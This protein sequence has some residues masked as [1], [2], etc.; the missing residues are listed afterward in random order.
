MTSGDKYVAIRDMVTSAPV[1]MRARSFAGFREL[2][3]SRGGNVEALLASVGLDPRVL[4][5]PEAAVPFARGAA[6]L[7]QAAE[8]LDLPDIGLRLGAYQ[9]IS[10]LGPVALVARHA[11]DLRG[12]LEGIGRHMAYHNTGMRLDLSV[13][14][15]AGEARLQCALRIDENVPVRHAMELTFVVA[16]KFLRTITQSDGIGWDVRFRHAPG[17]SSARYRKAFGCAAIFQQP[18]DAISF[19]ARLLDTAVDTANAELRRQA[20]RYIAHVVRRFPL[21]IASQTQALVERQLATGDCNIALIAGMLRLHERTLQRR[22]HEQGL[23][24]DTIVDR[25]RRERAREYLLG[26]AIPLTQVA[27]LLGYSEHTAF[28]R[29]C[30]R[31]FGESPRKLRRR[32]AD[33]LGAT[34]R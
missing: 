31:W 4:G 25:L 21:D 28:T 27:A 10:V 20:E 34:N 8:A 15:I 12:A 18:F 3:T 2:V 13:D 23:Q 14:A 1:L 11:T 17:L 16:S 30:R 5:E 32:G 9:D 24:F 19:P 22:L 26:S 33:P 6:L 29:A 7:E